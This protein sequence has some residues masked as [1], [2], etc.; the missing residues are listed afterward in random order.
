M[1]TRQR[2]PSDAA[3]W[4]ARPRS[5][6]GHPRPG[7]RRSPAREH[8]RGP[9][10]ACRRPAGRRPPVARAGRSRPRIRSTVA[11]AADRAAGRRRLLPRLAALHGHNRGPP[12]RRGRRHH[13]ARRRIRSGT[14]RPRPA[15]RVRRALYRPP[16]RLRPDVPPRLGARRPPRGH[17]RPDHRRPG[18]CPRLAEHDQQWHHHRVELRHTAIRPAN[19]HRPARDTQPHRG[20]D[21][22]GCAPPA[23][24]TAPCCGG[25]G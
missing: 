15:R 23:R 9:A 22:R 8:C 18:V 6:G 14:S 20:S 16:P 21:R 2:S 17:R 10:G 5:R 7:R 11:N 1:L 4:C 3:P 13:H 24:R 25:G 12:P 19:H